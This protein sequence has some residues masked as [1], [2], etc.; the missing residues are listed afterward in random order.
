[1]FVFHDLLLMFSS[2]L[3]IQIRKQCHGNQAP[4][5][6]G[7]EGGERGWGA[8]GGRGRGVEGG[9]HYSR[10]QRFDVDYPRCTIIIQDFKDYKK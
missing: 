3:S 8:G 9:D 4:N 6:G 5:T 7:S 2:K 1:M 10:S